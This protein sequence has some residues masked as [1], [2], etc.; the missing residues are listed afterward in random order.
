MVNIP[1]P[2]L[3]RA[4]APRIPPRHQNIVVT[5]PPSRRVKPSRSGD[6]LQH[7]LSRMATFNQE[8]VEHALNELLVRI[9]PDDPNEDEA[10]ANQRFDEAFEFALDEL[11]AAGEP[12]V[13]PDVNHVASLID[14][15]SM[16]SL[17]PRSF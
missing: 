2:N 1:N 14:R 4:P 12:S 3:V 13:V 8:R 6:A 5:S 10:S 15:R 7:N 16:S 11:V 17:I 9:V